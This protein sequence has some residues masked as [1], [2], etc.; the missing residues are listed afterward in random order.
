MAGAT[1]DIS[2]T[3]K[4]S[5]EHALAIR[6]TSPTEDVES[7]FKII[8][9]TSRAVIKAVKALP[10]TAFEV[11]PTVLPQISASEIPGSKEEENSKTEDDQDFQVEI[12]VTDNLLEQ[13]PVPETLTYKRPFRPWR[14]ARKDKFT[15]QPSTTLEDLAGMVARRVG[16][17][18]DII[19]LFT[20]ELLM[21]HV[22]ESPYQKVLP[23]RTS[24]GAVRLSCP[25]S[26]YLH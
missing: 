26:G 5:R 17:S 7:T 20:D 18:T 24:L 22:G 8:S 11:P 9:I 21:W 16:C 10:A 15:V 4:I 13:P 3:I 6:G 14:P 25:W 2:V 1:G 23:P 19:D 12:H